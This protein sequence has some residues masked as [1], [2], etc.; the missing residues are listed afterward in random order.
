MDAISIERNSFQIV[1]V[2]RLSQNRTKRPTQAIIWLWPIVWNGNPK[3]L[4]VEDTQ[5]KMTKSVH[6]KSSKTRRKVEID[7]YELE[8]KISTSPSVFQAEVCTI[9]YLRSQTV[10]QHSGSMWTK[11]TQIHDGLA[12]KN[13]ESLHQSHFLVGIV[14]SRFRCH[15]QQ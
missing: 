8:C 3:S 5:T 14:K 13:A 9:T 15:L 7:L 6:M 2:N 4:N 10:K 12:K 11:G 1:K